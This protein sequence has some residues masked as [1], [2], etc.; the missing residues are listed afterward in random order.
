LRVKIKKHNIFDFSALYSAM[1][2]TDTNEFSDIFFSSIQIDPPV[3][4]N[5]KEHIPHYIRA[6]TA[7]SQFVAA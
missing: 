4:M 7:Q 1:N 2:S 6:A 5:Y 3:E